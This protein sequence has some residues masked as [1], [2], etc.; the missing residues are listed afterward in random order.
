MSCRANAGTSHGIAQQ[1]AEANTA[2]ALQA[3]EDS[4]AVEGCRQ[5]MMQLIITSKQTC[6]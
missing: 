4:E 2:P 3:V 6:L 1:K 5:H